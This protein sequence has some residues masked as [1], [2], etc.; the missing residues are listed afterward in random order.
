MIE[1]SFP[2][3][4]QLLNHRQENEKILIVEDIHSIRTAI[5]DVLAIEYSAFDAKNYSEAVEILK[6]EKIDLLITDIKMPGKSG[7]DLIRHVREHYPETLYTLITAYNIND[8]IKFAKDYGV[9]NII[10][11]Y[12]FWIY[13][14]SPLWLTSY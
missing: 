11:K 10:P 12:S 4:S 2:S 7:L 8:Y 14:S 9:W 6:S 5:K 13:D 1:L 3:Q